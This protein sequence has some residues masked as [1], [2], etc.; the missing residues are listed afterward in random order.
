MGF[1]S[2]GAEAAASRAW[3][4]LEANERAALA[5]VYL[6]NAAGTPV[7]FRFLARALAASEGSAGALSQIFCTL[8]CP[9]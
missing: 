1:V 3:K 5:F 9:S 4:D 7:A 6:E 8:V 2:A